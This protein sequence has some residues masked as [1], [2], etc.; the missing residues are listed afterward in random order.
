[1]RSRLTLRV[2]LRVNVCIDGVCPHG[3]QRVWVTLLEKEADVH[4]PKLFNW[5]EVNYWNPSLP[6]TQEF[7]KLHNTVPC[8]RFE[9]EE[10]R[11][12]VPMCYWIDERW[13]VSASDTLCHHC[14]CSRTQ[15]DH[16]HLTPFL[17]FRRIPCPV[18]SSSTI[19]C[20][21]RV[22]RVAPR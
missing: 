18:V 19:R 21:R 4:A 22:R 13:K 20:S 5:V 7:L 3:L 12:S 16:P 8:G 2:C 1:M 11:E 15:S 17:M 6:L 9:G 14:A 10:L